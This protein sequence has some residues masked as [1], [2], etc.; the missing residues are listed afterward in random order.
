MWL[1]RDEHQTLPNLINQQL[2]AGEDL[3][4]ISRFRMN[5]GGNRITGLLADSIV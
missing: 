3:V 4:K 1:R 2:R 5:G